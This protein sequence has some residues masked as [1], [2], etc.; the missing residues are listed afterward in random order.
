MDS[1]KLNRIVGSLV[2]LV[3]LVV[4]WFTMQSSVSFWDCGEFAAS[5]YLMQVPHPPGTPFFLLL[6]KIFSMIPFA[7]DIGYR[8]NL[9]SVFS[10]A[11]AGLFLY[12]TVVKFI[13]ASRGKVQTSLKD[14]LYT[15]IAGAIGAFSFIFCET[16]WFNGV[17]SEVYANSTFFIAF[18]FWLI[19]LWNEKAD[20]T[21]SSKFIMLIAYLIGLSIGVH[22]M[23]VLAVVPIVMIIYFRKYLKDEAVLLNHPIFSLDMLF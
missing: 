22:L 1:K 20:E 18:I 21:D 15:Y 19:A 17:E 9:I 13:E 6:G 2:F 5:S 3:G 4:Y 16:V 10:T 7:Q 14:S 23:A 11:F 12:L 8:I